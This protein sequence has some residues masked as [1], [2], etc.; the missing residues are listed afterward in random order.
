VEV[1]MLLC[2]GEDRGRP[3]VKGGSLRLRLAPGGVQ[4]VLV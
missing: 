4:V 3:M 1:E 2:L